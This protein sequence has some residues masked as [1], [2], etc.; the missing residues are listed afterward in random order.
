MNWKYTG[1]LIQLDSHQVYAKAKQI[2]NQI[3]SDGT[4]LEASLK[5]IMQLT[6]FS[7]LK[8]ARIGTFFC[9][10]TNNTIDIVK[11]LI[12]KFDII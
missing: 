10:K 4:Y 5:A 1:R 8:N 11:F 12:H 2:D 3:Y 6:D 7:F 9:D